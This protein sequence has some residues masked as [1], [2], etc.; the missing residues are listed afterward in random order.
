[1]AISRKVLIQ[2]SSAVLLLFLISLSFFEMN[3]SQS[4][5][6]ELSKES[7]PLIENSWSASSNAETVQAKAKSVEAFKRALETANTN[8]VSTAPIQYPDLLTAIRETEKLKVKDAGI[9]P[10]GVK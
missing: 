4:S 3:G 8:P 10:F 1:M 6:P 5:S 2:L 9:S 7:A